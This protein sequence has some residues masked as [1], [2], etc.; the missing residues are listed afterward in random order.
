MNALGNIQFT[1]AML[2]YLKKQKNAHI[3][4]V[5]STSAVPDLKEGD[6]KGWKSYGAS[7]WAFAGYTKTLRLDLEKEKSQIKLTAFFPGG[8]ESKLYERAG[9]AWAH[10]QPW[11]MKT[12]D[13]AE[14]ILFVLS[15]PKDVLIPRVVMTKHNP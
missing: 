9:R 15:R 12:K 6:N 3:V 10:G 14:T 7:K 8:F 1:E 13:V 2:P 11:M 4:N 5:I